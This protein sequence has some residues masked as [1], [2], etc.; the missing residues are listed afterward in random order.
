[1][2]EQQPLTDL[3]I[4]ALLGML[5]PS[6]IAKRD[7]GRG[8]K[9]S[10][11]EAWDVKAALI[12]IF[13]F[14]NFS[15]ET[16]ENRIL[17]AREVDGGRGSNWSVTV[18]TTVRLH[19]FQT[20]AV[21]TESAAKTGVNRDYGEALD[22]AIKTA[23]SDALKRCAIYLGTQYGLSLY[24]DGSYRDVVQLVF[25]P[26]QERNVPPA[27]V[28]AIEQRKAGSQQQV[29]TPPGEGLNLG[30]LDS[31]PE[32]KAKADELVRRAFS[33]KAARD[34]E[35]ERQTSDTVAEATYDPSVHGGPGDGAAEEVPASA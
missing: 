29:Q 33:A 30:G 18:M 32:Q 21:Y 35:A 19:I 24:D 28:Q 34:A 6:R 15:A 5:N 23:S 17:D 25:A 8:T 16:T 27:M 22:M 1:M 31:D 3:Q 10:Y 14:G 13:G 7:G 2:I 26:G 11:L 9:L 20:G 12:K 4:D